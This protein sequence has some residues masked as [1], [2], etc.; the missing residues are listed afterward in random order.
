M[1][2][3]VL[4]ICCAVAAA[5]G[6]AVSMAGGA[7]G[8]TAVHNGK[9]AYTGAWVS[10][11]VRLVNPD[12][13][14]SRLLV[15]SP[16]GACAN[17]HGCGM[18]SVTWSPDGRKL[19]FSREDPSTSPSTRSLF[20]INPDGTDERHLLTCRDFCSSPAWSPDSLRLAVV[21]RDVLYVV[22]ADGSGLH[23][24]TRRDEYT[25]GDGD[26]APAWS[27][28]GTRILFLRGSVYTVK[29]DG[30]G[31]IRIR[32]TA[33]ASSA[34][35]L[36][37]GRTIG[38]TVAGDKLFSVDADG[39]HLR[40]QLTMSR[41]DDLYD[42]AWS[43]DGGSVVYVEDRRIGGNEGGYAEDVW[44]TR[45]DGGRRT[46]LLHQ[47]CCI[48]FSALPVWSPDGKEIAIAAGPGVFLVNFDG[49]GLH[50]LRGL[51]NWGGWGYPSIAWQ[52]VR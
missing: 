11:G 48:N 24:L 45:A 35:W 38:F 1:T 34:H 17:V 52:P 31:L 12:G 23:R 9:I 32:G 25:E 43:P 39:S 40:L 26:G 37:D 15:P 28:D 46:R 5:A 30:F 44:V 3:R 41:S 14:G 16:T 4:L 42:A 27:P 22:D 36:P 13:S 50:R 51:E 2:R 18:D 21:N 10:D 47:D 19:T 6:I 29:P 20:V 33:G 8:S 49:T 7:I